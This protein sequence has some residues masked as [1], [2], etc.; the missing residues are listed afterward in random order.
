MK[1][2]LFSIAVTIT[3]IA[4]A[5]TAIT[6]FHIISNLFS[7]PSYTYKTNLTQTEKQEAAKKLFQ[8]TH[9]SSLYDNITVEDII[10]GDTDAYGR[11]C[12]VV[13]YK[14]PVKEYTAVSYK[15]NGIDK[16]G[17]VY[18][19][20]NYRSSVGGAHEETDAYKPYY[21]DGQRQFGSVWNTK[22][23]KDKEIMS[24]EHP[25]GYGII[26][27]YFKWFTNILWW[28]MDPFTGVEVSFFAM[29]IAFCRALLRGGIVFLS[30][31]FILLW[32]QE[33]AFA[34]NL[35]VKMV[36]K[37]GG[38]VF[39]IAGAFVT[40]GLFFTTC[41]LGSP[42][43]NKIG[44]GKGQ[45]HI[46]ATWDRHTGSF[47]PQ[48]AKAVHVIDKDTMYTFDGPSVRQPWE[49]SDITKIES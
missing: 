48:T 1:K 10:V 4:T 41:A 15:I 49:A 21:I 6:G 5:V 28:I 38:I 22:P 12:A 9:A 26:L 42:L 36:G 40:F 32:T 23:L 47:M 34:S 44:F 37:I 29:I 7:R 18:Y 17:I 43:S 39:G 24:T 2:T 16:S 20:L 8:H 25:E 46:F 11:F 3:A 33:L 27:R 31:I 30:W 35:F 19:T 13:L 14:N 45:K